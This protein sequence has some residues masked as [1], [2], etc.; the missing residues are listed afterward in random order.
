MQQ[1]PQQYMQP[2]MVRYPMMPGHMM[3]SHGQ[4]PRQPPNMMFHGQ[5]GVRGP[6]IPP[7]AY[8][9]TGMGQQ[10]RANNP[11]YRQQM[12]PE[13]MKKM[14]KEKFY[15]EQKQKLKQFH[16]QSVD[17]NKLIESM[18]G[19]TEKPKVK[20][21][22][23]APEEDF[24]E[25][26]G[27]FIGGPSV[28][29]CSQSEPT[30][31]A[32]EETSDLPPVTETNDNQSPRGSQ[33]EEKKVDINAM[34]MECS[35][36]TAPNKA[37]T[38]QKRSLKQLHPS[39]HAVKQHESNQA[40]QWKQM[41]LDDLGDIF[42]VEEPVI[43]SRETTPEQ[44]DLGLPHWCK[45][46]SKIPELYKHVLEASSVEGVIQ[47]ERVYPILILSGLAK[48]VLGHIWSM[49]N[50]MSPGQL[51]KEELYLVLGF[52]F[53]A[54]KNQPLSIELLHRIPQAP[55]PVL[56]PP[57]HPPAT[58]QIPPPA[59]NQ[60]HTAPQINQP[61]VNQTSGQ[62]ST[63][64][65]VVPPCSAIV[66]HPSMPVV[67]LPV[68]S[69]ISLT[70][71][72]INQGQISNIPSPG[73]TSGGWHS[74]SIGTTVKP[75][76]KQ[77]DDDFADFQEA[78]K[79]V[80]EVVSCKS[81]KPV[82]SREDKKEYLYSVPVPDDDLHDIQ[83]STEQHYSNV[84]NFFGS[85][86]SSGVSTPNSLDDDFD[87]FKSAGRPSDSSQFTSSEQS[88]N[89]D[90]KVLESYL[91]DFSKKKQQ[92]EKQESPLH[93]P[94]S[95][96]TNLP[97]SAYS[98]NVNPI[99]A[100][101]SLWPKHDSQKVTTVTPVVITKSSK[102]TTFSPQSSDSEF[103]DFQQAP[104]PIEDNLTSSKSATDLIGD[105]D[106]YAALRTL[107]SID[108]TGPALFGT[109]ENNTENVEMDEG[110]WADFQSTDTVVQSDQSASDNIFTSS[111]E[112][113]SSNNDCSGF[114]DPSISKQE[115]N[116][117]NVAGVNDK[118]IE[119]WSDFSQVSSGNKN[120][121]EEWADFQG[122]SQ[123]SIDSK[124]DESPA[125]IISVSQSDLVNV[126]KKNLQHN[127]IL[128]L[129]K[130]RSDPG[131]LSSYII[132]DLSQKEAE[133]S[134]TTHQE[135]KGYLETSIDESRPFQQSF[136]T[137]KMEQKRDI[138]K[139][140]VDD[141]EDFFH[142]PPPIDDGIDDDDDDEYGDFS[143]GYDIDEVSPSQTHPP[144][145]K[146]IFSMYGM[147]FTS[148]S[149][150]GT[151]YKKA[152]ADSSNQLTFLNDG[153]QGNNKMG[154]VLKPEDTNS[155]S[156][157]ELPF[158]KSVVQNVKDS[159]S[160][161][162]SSNEFT[163]DFT[164]GKTM[165]DSKSIDSLDLKI[166]E[167]KSVDSLDMKAGESK[168]V[169]SLDLEDKSEND[170]QTSGD[171]D[172]S[173]EE[174]NTVS[175]VSQEPQPTLEP[176]PLPL[177]G[178]RYSGIMEDISGS[179][180]YAYEWQ[181]CLENCCRMIKDAN[182]IFNSISSSGVCNEVIRSEQGTEY[183]QGIV[184]IY[185]IVCRITLSMKASAL[186][187]DKLSQ[188][189]KD[190]DLVWNNLT[191]FL[192]GGNIMPDDNT[193]SFKNSLIKSD[194]SAAQMRACGVCLLDVNVKSKD[195]NSEEDSVKLTYGGRQYH[196]TCANFWVNCV[197]SMLP[198]LKLPELL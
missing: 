95:K 167:S 171:S 136:P 129:F 77:D 138:P 132:P 168:S 21:D 166:S 134:T 16:T 131:I 5:M 123:S 194:D 155:V 88:E 108:T 39:H 34:M 81:S 46:E 107:E 86:D 196:A 15:L 31:L 195:F 78:P 94:I 197:D 65:P 142:G 12:S 82:S 156:S 56:A 11:Q 47:T 105:E 127:E 62:P 170:E 187:T 147:E 157:L 120:E 33:K 53:L 26:F 9:P 38:F 74:H 113:S 188:T 172:K 118:T 198:S 96:T 27:D 102:T 179:D 130:P 190:V 32:M 140:S 193:L 63:E 24:G 58:S 43:K 173:I 35:D 6:G 60:V 176:Q 30:Q 71:D 91:D 125:P 2:G 115:I 150:Q 192:V 52:I 97:P 143:H 163:P 66:Q 44:K 189:V 75:V 122:P 83:M 67:G 183:V 141:D 57:Q 61:L 145:N 149:K 14:E 181:R 175:I 69:T 28:S 54:Q 148:S 164:Q 182:N 72:I 119:E 159:D 101:K 92:M 185:R 137:P 79:E 49:C 41:N 162:V 152:D 55:I 98:K 135:Q 161:S 186:S 100:I 59:V 89:E 23:T 109:E 1:F 50:K 51:I 68:Q 85:D 117:F 73:S 40:R 4:L 104:V 184:E 110:E 177:F 114:H 45:D 37:K 178:D 3:P 22:T 19:K 139:L 76:Q 191:A 106:K 111:A 128:G 160:L 112:T 7:P 93:R 99:P 10:Y 64:P 48:D 116:L 87:D 165:A 133:S 153:L 124:S 151:T 20:Q 126:K 146:K 174:N 13:T 17:P 169:D 29:T 70:T 84:S 180:K 8:R 80:K 154:K 144:E 25:S 42:V 158:T 36:L 121:G 18:F 90:F 103:A